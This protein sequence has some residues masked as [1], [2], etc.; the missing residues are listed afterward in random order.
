MREFIK[1]RLE[2]AAVIAVGFATIAAAM[3]VLKL[4]GAL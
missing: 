3:G 4:L 2:D 1:R